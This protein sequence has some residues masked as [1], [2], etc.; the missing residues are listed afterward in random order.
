MCFY[1]PIWYGY[2]QISDVL[3]CLACLMLSILYSF[4]A[5]SALLLY[6]N[7]GY[8][9]LKCKTA[10]AQNAGVQDRVIQNCH[11]QSTITDPSSAQEIRSL[12]YSTSTASPAG[13]R[14]AKFDQSLWIY[15]RYSLLFFLAAVVTWVRPTIHSLLKVAAGFTKFIGHHRRRHQKNAKIEFR[16]PRA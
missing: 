1:G 10:L 14:Q 7:M 8:V 4:I 2:H 15:L 16:H 9:I 11:T 6:A 13:K 3:S 12:S 5:L